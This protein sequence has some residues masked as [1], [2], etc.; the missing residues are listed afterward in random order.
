MSPLQELEGPAG[1][2][3]VFD[4]GNWDP[5][6]FSILL[7]FTQNCTY[8]VWSAHLMR[9]AVAGT[10]TR[11]D[12]PGTWARIRNDPC[13]HRTTLSSDTKTAATLS[14]IAAWGRVDD[15]DKLLLV[16]AAAVSDIDVRVL[17]GRTGR[18]ATAIDV[19]AGDR[20]LGQVTEA[21]V[22]VRGLQKSEREAALGCKNSLR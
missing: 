14:R 8:S 15:W 9:G 5:S 22:D 4:T 19:D 17:T 7:L 11:S 6:M 13:R 20:R 18:Q 2:T 3:D 1:S 21:L 16:P 10:R 12:R